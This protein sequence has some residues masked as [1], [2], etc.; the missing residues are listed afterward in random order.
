[1]PVSPWSGQSH[2]DAK[3]R[4]NRYV[5]D[6]MK[7]SGVRAGGVEGQ[8]G[9]MFTKEAR[10]S[11]FEWRYSSQRARRVKA[12]DSAAGRAWDFE[13]ALINQPVEVSCELGIC[14]LGFDSSAVLQAGGNE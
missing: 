5:A 14:C 10:S 6:S 13:T 4:S 7:T 2:M 11:C 12:W 8:V 3:E 9:R 1:M